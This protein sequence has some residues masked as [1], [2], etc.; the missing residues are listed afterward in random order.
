MTEYDSATEWSEALTLADLE[1]VLSK[2]NQ[3][4]KV[5]RYIAAQIRTIWKRYVHRD[6][7]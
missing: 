5:T 4:Q 1:T 6:R 3:T 7:E 2:R